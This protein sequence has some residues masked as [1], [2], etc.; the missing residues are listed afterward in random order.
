MTSEI[1]KTLIRKSLQLPEMFDQV[2]II[3]VMIGIELVPQSTK[4][5]RTSKAIIFHLQDIVLIDTSQCDNALVDYSFF[6]S[7]TNLFGGISG[8]ISLLGDAVEYRT[9]KYIVEIGF[10]FFYLFQRVA[11]GTYCPE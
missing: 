8:G 1:K 3:I 2:L 7:L 6:C 9:K 10:L 5:R 11:G 4:N